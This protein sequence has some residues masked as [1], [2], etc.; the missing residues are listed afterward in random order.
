MLAIF[1]FSITSV[2]ASEI[3]TPIASEDTS[4]V[5]L[6]DIDKVI[7]DNPQTSEEKLE[8]GVDDEI[9]NEQTDIDVLG[10]SPATYSHL[11]SEISKT[12]NV[13]LAN[14]TYTYDD[15]ATAITVSEDNKVIDGNGAVIDMA[16]S[17]IRAFTVS[18][19]GVTIKNLTIKNANYNGD[20]GAIYFSQSGTVSNCNFTN[21]QATSG[22]AVY[23]NT[24]GEVTNC[25]F[26]N[27]SATS[28]GGAIWMDSGSVENC[29]F[30]NN[31]ANDGGGAIIMGSG[32]VTNCNFTDNKATSGGAVHFSSTGTVTNCNFTNNQATRWGGAVYF[33]KGTVKNCNFTDNHASYGGAVYFNYDGDVRNCNLSFDWKCQ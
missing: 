15:G 26:T 20:G 10:D 3:D 32:T 12:G 11:A 31:S 27:N 4:Q 28:Y 24:N 21:N 33:Y 19:S 29:N 23:F 2:C 5:G 13:I 6:S 22:G 14:K 17:T 30:T 18:A 8:L 1:L 9:L 25:N 7:E 16:G